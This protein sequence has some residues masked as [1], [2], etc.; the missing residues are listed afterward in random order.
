NFSLMEVKEFSWKT[1]DGKQIYAVEW[2]VANARA[3]IGLVHGMGEHCR[4]YDGMVDWYRQHGIAFVGY[5]R[6][7]FGRSE[8]QRAYAESYRDYLDEVARL[9]VACE[10]RY[11][12]VPVFLYGHSF[13]G[14]TLLRY[15]IKRQPRI[16]GAIVTGPHI[17]LGFKANPLVV[18]LGRVTNTLWPTFSQP[19]Q[20]DVN[21]LS[22]TPEVVTAYQND[23]LNTDRLTSRT[24]IALL[25]VANELDGWTGTL[26]VPTLLMHGT[27]D[28]I[29]GWKGSE[30]F[31]QRNSADLTWKAWPG[32][33]HEIHHEPEREQ[34]FTYT[35]GWL[36]ERLSNA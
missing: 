12:D 4:R 7:G 20:L 33:Y 31:A 36:E 13:G 5:D 21:L 19:N 17:R 11:P 30:A 6:Q 8:G 16:S 15:L 3:V 1:S 27:A 14:Q 23:P 26:P 35:L 24:G 25:D 32:L 34:V 22:R 10:R 18:A 28:G 2:P 29:T 9:V